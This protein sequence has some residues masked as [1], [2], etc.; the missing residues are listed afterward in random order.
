MDINLWWG[1]LNLMPVYP[2][3]G[4]QVSR[5]V[6]DWLIPGGQGIRVAL[7]VSLGVAILLAAFFALVMNQMYSAVFFG[8]MAF[9]SFQLMQ[10]TPVRSQGYSDDRV[11]WERDPDSWKRGSGDRW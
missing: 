5:D 6:F 11:P 9:S 4:G 1:V 7:G 2:L 8:L 3:D 10:A